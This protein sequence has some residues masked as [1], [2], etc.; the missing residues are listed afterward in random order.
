MPTVHWA[1]NAL[2]QAHGGRACFSETGDREAVFT[3]K[4]RRVLVLSGVGERSFVCWKPGYVT[5][6]QG[7][8]ILN[9]AAPIGSKS[10][11]GSKSNNKE[12][13]RPRYR[14]RF[15]FRPHL[16]LKIRITFRAGFHPSL[17]RLHSF[18]LFKCSGVNA[19][20]NAYSTLCS[21]LCRCTLLNSVL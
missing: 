17:F 3:R 14:Y 20:R 5:P 16:L 4:V 11:S 13:I 7:A 18:I 10:L 8:A 15:R 19:A 12:I 6:L 1:G 9:M 21:C 2:M